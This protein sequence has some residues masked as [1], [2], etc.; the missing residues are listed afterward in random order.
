MAKCSAVLKLEKV[1]VNLA[2]DLKCVNSVFG[3]LNQSV[4]YG[5]LNCEG[6]CSLEGG[7]PRALDVMINII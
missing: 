6:D 4:K 7:K 2:F 3:L 1:N 5:F